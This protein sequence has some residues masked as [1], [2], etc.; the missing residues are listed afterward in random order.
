MTS[1]VMLAI[2]AGS[3]L[4]ATTPSIPATA[5]EALPTAG[6]VSAAGA[7]AIGCTCT[8]SM[9]GV[10]ACSGQMRVVAEYAPI[11][12]AVIEIGTIRRAATANDA[13]DR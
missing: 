8:A 12:S 1:L 9:V 10:T 5:T 3:T 7:A 4:D 11:R 2:C 6:Q 13:A